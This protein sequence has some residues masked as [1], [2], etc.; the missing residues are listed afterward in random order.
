LIR[1]QHLIQRLDREGAEILQRR[2]TARRLRRLQC[3]TQHLQAS[4]DDDLN[5]TT[6]VTSKKDDEDE[7]TPAE[8]YFLNHWPTADEIKDPKLLEM[9]FY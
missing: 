8:I 9:I 1:L 4:C 5:T 3:R 2:T 7:L 6:A